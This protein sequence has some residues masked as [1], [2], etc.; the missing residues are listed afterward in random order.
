[1]E[2]SRVDLS[3]GFAVVA[4][5]VEAAEELFAEAVDDADVAELFCPPLFDPWPMQLIKKR[6]T[7]TPI[8]IETN[9]GAGFLE[10]PPPGNV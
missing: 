10:P 7:T 3:T 5:V 4:A 8:M 1:M 6:I 2:D 9:F